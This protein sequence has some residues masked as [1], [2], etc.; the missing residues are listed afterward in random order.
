[1]KL[2]D[3]KGRILGKVNII[4]FA[5]ILF[6]IFLLPMLYYGN[7]IIY[8]KAKTPRVKYKS[9]DITGVVYGLNENSAKEIK[10]GDQEFDV[11]KGQLLGEILHVG[12]F[13]KVE[14]LLG[15]GAGKQVKVED[16]GLILVLKMEGEII[17]N[18]FYFKKKKIEQS[19][20]FVFRTSKYSLKIYPIEDMAQLEKIK[21]RILVKRT[22]GE[23]AF[24]V[25]AGDREY[26]QSYAS[27][28]EEVL[29]EI[30][31]VISN[32]PSKF[33]LI[34]KA[35]E[36]QKFQESPFFRDVELVMSLNVEM[37]NKEAFYKNIPVK[38]GEKIIFRTTRY[39]L[40]GLILEIIDDK[41]RNQ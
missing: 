12:E 37:R 35:G 27:S 36:G 23:Q 34:G 1:M 24:L 21:I 41:K 18:A 6:L 20:S 7:K 29:G 4:D 26:R 5:V 33:L 15:I 10:R 22:T 14:R 8:K 11:M 30:V 25:L 13:R 28:E 16:T 9:V 2:F 31:R 40:S 38:I 39:N 32:K 17:N 19:T 3:D